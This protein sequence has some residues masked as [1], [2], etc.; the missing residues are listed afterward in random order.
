MELGPKQLEWIKSLREHPERQ[1][2]GALGI[3][4][5]DR[6]QV[7]CLGEYGLICNVIRFYPGHR[8]LSCHG[9]WRILTDVWKDIGLH[10]DFGDF[11]IYKNYKGR[12]Y[13]S[14]AKMNDGGMTWSEI[15]DYVESDPDNVFNF[16]Y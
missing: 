16:S 11:V 3:K 14:L 5:H 10:S 9:N 13:T 7:C 4:S 6:I 8:E 12:N 2:K 15:A 1:L